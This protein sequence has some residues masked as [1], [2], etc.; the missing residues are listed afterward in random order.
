MARELKLTGIGQ[1]FRMLKGNTR[2][3]VVFEPLWSIPFALYSFYLGLYLKGRGIGDAQIGYLISIGFVAS[4]IFSL[5]AGKLTDVLGRKRTTLIFDML[6]WPGAML[7]YLFADNFWMFALAQVVNSMTKITAVSW[8]LMVIEDADSEQQVA[9]YN[10]INAIVIA[11]GLLTPLAGI[12]VKR[13]GII[14]GEQVMLGLAALSMAAMIL[15]R[16]CYYRET[17][18]GRQIINERRAQLEPNDRKEDGG[19]WRTLWTKPL[20]APVLLFSMLFNI[21][22]PIGTY[23]SLYYGPYLTEVLKLDK[24]EIALLGGI[25]AGVMLAVIWLLVPLVSRIRRSWLLFAGIGIQMAA[26]VLLMVIPPGSFGA[27][28]VVI[29]LFAVGY[30]MTKPLVDS[31]LA[32]VTTGRERAGIYAIHNAGIS[33]FSAGLGLGSGYLYRQNPAT[34]YLASIMILLLGVGCLVWLERQSAK[35]TVKW[36]AQEY[37]KC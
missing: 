6:A 24:A 9:A 19:V 16:N 31:I 14:G 27:A 28:V 12:I 37:C 35:Q 3:S 13:C 22:I 29:G 36:E 1:S 8:N 11:S 25:N 18:V 26:L 21:Y 17:S 5:L 23:S 15:G 34:L 2:I 32:I 10:L 33:L 7:I 20:I 30:G 4:I